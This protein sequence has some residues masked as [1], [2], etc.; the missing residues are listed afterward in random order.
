MTKLIAGC[1]YLGLRVARRWI[2]AGAAV[3][4]ITRSPD[5]ADDLR[6]EGIAPITAD[7]T[8]PESL[9]G[10]PAAE[11]VLWSVGWD[12]RGEADRRAVYV[13]G[14]RALLDALPAGLRRIVM[15]S[16]TGVYGQA[17]GRWVDE[18]SPCRPVREAGRVM[19]A[20]EGVLRNHPLGSRAI[21]LRLA[22]LYGPGRIPRL[23]Q[24]RAGEPLVASP[25]GHLNLIHVDDAAAV[26]LAAESRA[27]PP[28]TYLVS[29]GHPTHQRGFY[30]KLAELLGLGPP[31][32][33]EPG[34]DAGR[35]QRGGN[36]RVRNA[37]ML[38]ELGI[39]LQ[40]P[41]YR[42]GLAAVVAAEKG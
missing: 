11:T 27:E 21:I 2:A 25:G 20:A 10:L 16:S 6:R 33:V 19:L 42:E 13:E 7:L 35:A 23:R 12:P 34:P 26:V 31:E 1:G 29:D 36:K 32:F 18:D 15:T 30:A 40:H 17:D 41:T 22:G 14:L 8:R 28:R 5:R 38:E 39:E 9:A 24:L 4:A 37:R 3:H